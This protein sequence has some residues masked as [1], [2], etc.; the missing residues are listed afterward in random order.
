MKTRSS[1]IFAVDPA[2][3]WK[4]TVVL[5]CHAGG[6]SH[7]FLSTTFRVFKLV[8]ISES[9]GGLYSSILPKR[10]DKG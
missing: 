7:G 10:I 6:R 9:L 2:G 3:V 5:D 4:N 8:N 1:F